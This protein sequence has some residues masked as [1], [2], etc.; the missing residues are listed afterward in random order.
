MQ[1]EQ[2][3]KRW[4]FFAPVIGKALPPTVSKTIQGMSNVLRAILLEKLSVWVYVTQ[5]AEVVFIM[6]TCFVSDPVTLQ[7][8]LMIYTFTGVRQ[9]GRGMWEETYDILKKEARTRNAR[10]IIAYT[11]NDKIAEH[12]EEVSG[13]K[14]S[15]TLI[16][17]EV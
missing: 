10:G 15:S 4:G 2:V 17:L 5:D 12:L 9:W 3:S 6:T 8:N 16:Q 13:A 14:T 11:Y 7:K 1:P